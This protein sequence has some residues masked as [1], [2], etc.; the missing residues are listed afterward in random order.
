MIHEI[1]KIYGIGFP[2]FLNLLNLLK[3]WFRQCRSKSLK[4]KALFKSANHFS[5]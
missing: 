2:I 5:E 3:S 4:G 1:K